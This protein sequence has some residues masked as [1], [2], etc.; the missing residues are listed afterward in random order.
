MYCCHFLIQRAGRPAQ[1]DIR[2]IDLQR[3]QRR[4]WLRRR[5]I[6]KDLAQLAYSAPRDRVGCKEQV[7][8]LHHYFGVR[9]LRRR[10]KRLIGAVMRKV[11][12]MQ[13]RLGAPP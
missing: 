6:V 4:R 8:L 1:F 12:V 9:K 2:L 7:A 10:D 5:W 13:R 3:V 11:R